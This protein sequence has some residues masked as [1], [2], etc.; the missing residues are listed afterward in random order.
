M[1]DPER[2]FERLTT[3]YLVIGAGAMSLAFADEIIHHSS[4]ARVIVVERRAAPGGHW[5]D[6][7]DF[8]KLHQPA[9]FYGVNSEPLGAGGEALASKGEILDYC[10]RVMAKLEAT[11]RATFYLEHDYCGDNRFVDLRDPTKGYVVDVRARLVD[12]TYGKITVPSTRPPA[13][14]VAEGVNLV[15]ING[16]AARTR[17]WAR[18]VIIGA[19]KTG[20]DAVL[21]L[22]SDGVSPER[23]SW[24]I[25]RDAWFI[26]RETVRP[27]IMI[28]DM[29]DQ[30]ITIIDAESAR[31]VFVRSE[32]AGRFFRL[33][34][35]IWPTAFRCATV[36][37][38]ELTSLRRIENIIR[39]GRIQRIEPD[40]IV[41][42]RGAH[43]T[44]ADTLHVD[45]TA[46]GLVRR[47]TTPVFSPR[48]I[49]LQPTFLCQP[50]F[51]AGAIAAAALRYRSDAARN[52]RMMPVPH[53]DQPWH[54]FEAAERTIANSVE[55]GFG[56]G[57]HFRRSRLCWAAHFSF[58]GFWVH[59]F[60]SVLYRGRALRKMPL[61]ALEMRDEEGPA[62]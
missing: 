2:A 7:Y 58:W 46:N 53:P 27:E 14:G 39:L 50:T 29:I 31:E 6:A 8:V 15:P 26:N 30:L 9:R 18:Y 12:G 61:L 17:D 11:G 52:R 38:S 16:L 49:T 13:Y 34:E 10:A 42:D 40:T 23:I 32:A 59:V 44:D 35:S 41:L 22:L 28:R 19:G 47:P 36:S 3:D 60:R 37:P 5:N 4:K 21:Y 20:M 55:W 54:Y 62:S 43:P 57:M 51:S 24:V 25:S 1:S 45:C 56:L 48:K 33:D